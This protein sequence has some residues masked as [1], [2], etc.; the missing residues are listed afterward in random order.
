MSMVTVLVTLVMIP[1]IT[2]GDEYA[3]AFD[4]DNNDAES[5]LVAVDADCDGIEGLWE[6]SGMF[7]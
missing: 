3:A 1:M 2:D 6:V 4:C 7:T 5:T